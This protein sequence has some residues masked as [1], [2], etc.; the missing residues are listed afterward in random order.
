MNEAPR[1]GDYPDAL[2]P[3]AVAVGSIEVLFETIAKRKKAKDVIEAGVLSGAAI[4]LC[5][6][7]TCLIIGKDLADWSRHKFITLQNSATDLMKKLS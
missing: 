2:L 6:P 7:L 1:Y 3:L 5:I 4:T